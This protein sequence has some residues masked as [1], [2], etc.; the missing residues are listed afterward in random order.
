MVFKDGK[1]AASLIGARP[2][3]KIVEWLNE[4]V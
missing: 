1:P 2:K 4:S 3:S